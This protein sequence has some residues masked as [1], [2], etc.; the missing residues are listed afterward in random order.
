MSVRLFPEIVLLVESSRRMPLSKALTLVFLMGAVSA[1]TD[2][3]ASFQT[4]P[5]QIDV[6]GAFGDFGEWTFTSGTG[7]NNSLLLTGNVEPIF[8]FV[9]NDFTTTWLSSPIFDK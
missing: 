8:D 3:F 5:V 4:L 1:T 2:E 6:T 7:N 9:P